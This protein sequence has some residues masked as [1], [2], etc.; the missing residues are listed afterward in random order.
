MVES[1]LEYNIY[2]KSEVRKGKQKKGV[3]IT[4]LRPE[5]KCLVCSKSKS[6]SQRPMVSEDLKESW[7]EMEGTNNA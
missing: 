5:G 1:H 2:T 3:C 7:K 4:A 6:A